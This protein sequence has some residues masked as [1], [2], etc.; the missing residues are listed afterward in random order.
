M[1]S[2]KTTG[3][4][5]LY[6]RNLAGLP[7]RVV[8]EKFGIPIPTLRLWERSVQLKEKAAKRF[9]KVIQSYGINTSLTWLLHG[10]QSDTIPPH[11]EPMLEEMKDWKHLIKDELDFLKKKYKNLQIYQMPDNSMLPFIHPGDYVAGYLT[12]DPKLLQNQLCIVQTIEGN[13]LVREVRSTSQRV[14]LFHLKAFNPTLEYPI[15][16]NQQLTKVA[17][18]IWL[19]KMK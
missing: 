16:Y 18:V 7:R 1:L 10:V 14:D 6:L 2:F 12:D 19:R 3:E 13:M 9:L 4:R 5:I 8:Q 15:L 17:K 11:V